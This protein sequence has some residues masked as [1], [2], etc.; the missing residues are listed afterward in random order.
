MGC[1]VRSG[2]HGR[3]RG[4]CATRSGSDGAG[5]LRTTDFITGK[6]AA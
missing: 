3:H 5:S 4:R 1:V 6:A 2:N